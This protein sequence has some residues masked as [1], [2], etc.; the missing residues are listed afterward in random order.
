MPEATRF[1]GPTNRARREVQR[2]HQP[3]PVRSLARRIAD[4]IPPVIGGWAPAPGSLVLREGTVVLEVADREAIGLVS[5][6]VRFGALGLEEAV[7]DG[8]DFAPAYA[9]S[10]AELIPGGVR[11]TLRRAAGWLDAFAVRVSASD[12]AGNVARGQAA[13]EVAGALELRPEK[14]AP[15]VRPTLEQLHDRVRAIF[16]QL[17]GG[18][19]PL[20]KR[21][22]EAVTA[23]AIA[24]LSHGL[25]GHLQWVA[26]QLPDSSDPTTIMRWARMLKTL[27]RPAAPARGVA[28]FTGEGTIPAGAVVVREDGA[29]YEVAADATSSA[30]SI[31]VE[32][33]ARI[34]GPQSNA[35]AGT[36]LR[37]QSTIP[38]IATTGAVTGDLEG[39]RDAD[40]LADT[41]QRYLRR[42]SGPPLGGGPGDYIEWARQVPQVFRAW[43]YPHAMGPGTVGL[44]FIVEGNNPIPSAELVARVR[45]HVLGRAPIGAQR[46]HVAAPVAHRVDLR[47]RLTPD[48]TAT[49]AAVVESL[50]A[51]FSGAAVPGRVLPRSHIAEAIS[52]AEGEH[53]HELLSPTSNVDPGRNGIPVLGD[54]AW[55]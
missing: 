51:L 15:Y 54:I 43:E 24:G 53:D 20:F 31:T 29:T 14:P 49:R 44:A 41:Q 37:L 2:Q 23:T 21:S 3:R 19:G 52:G 42:L 46:L 12:A 10:S 48:N 27:P 17:P 1:R 8:V 36:G 35:G 39:G 28:R 13:F 55:S 26:D 11:L 45:T 38:G 16:R 18:E 50:R 7:Y 34:P 9:T 33:V 4:A 22:F 30:G 47:L 6:S 32:L 5:A 25:H 40:S